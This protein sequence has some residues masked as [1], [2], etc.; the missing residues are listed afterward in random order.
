MMYWILLSILVILVAVLSQLQVDYDPEVV[1]R[2]V[3][4]VGSPTEVYRY[5]SD[6]KLYAKVNVPQLLQK[7]DCIQQLLHR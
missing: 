2:S 1:K 6:M 4:L 3:V 5:V 7:L